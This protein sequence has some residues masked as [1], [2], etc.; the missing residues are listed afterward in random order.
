MARVF[1]SPR[2]F[3]AYGLYNTV[4]AAI[5]LSLRFFQSRA[6][7]VM[8]PLPYRRCPVG[9]Y[10]FRGDGFNNAELHITAAAIPVLMDLLR[11]LNR[12]HDDGHGSLLGDL[13]HPIVEGQQDASRLMW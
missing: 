4:Y 12:R 10:K 5:F 9:A 6:Q 8:Y 2:P 11:S 3:P 1:S 13:E 7:F